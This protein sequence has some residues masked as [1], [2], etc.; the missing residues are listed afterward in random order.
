MLE[1]ARAG[2]VCGRIRI[3]VGDCVVRGP[4]WTSGDEDGGDGGIG[5]VAEINDMDV[6]VQW[7]ADML[8]DFFT[9]TAPPRSPSPPPRLSDPDRRR[10]LLT[11]LDSN[12][13]P[14]YQC[15]SEQTGVTS[16]P[17]PGLPAPPLEPTLSACG[18]RAEQNS[19]A[20]LV[21]VAMLL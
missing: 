21:P 18:V 7:A 6:H 13:L 19:P 15:S 3:N 16:F 17:C 5:Q 8:T 14:S 11:H 1:R 10:S 20:C 9:P 4:E 12:G 2:A